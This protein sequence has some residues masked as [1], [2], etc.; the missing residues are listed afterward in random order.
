MAGMIGIPSASEPRSNEFFWSLQRVLR[1]H[2]DVLLA[3]SA[4][5]EVAVNRNNLAKQALAAECEWLW[6]ADDDTI[7]QDD[8]L[9]RMVPHLAE[10]EIVVPY[11]V[12]RSLPF[13]GLLYQWRDGSVVTPNPD[14]GSAVMEIDQG[15][16]GGMLIATSAFKKM[17][18]PWF[19]VGEVD[20]EHQQDDTMF[21]K[22]AR[23]AGVRIVCDPGVLIGHLLR[24][25]AW[26]G[27]ND[28]IVLGMGDGLAV[29]VSR[30]YIAGAPRAGALVG[31]GGNGT[32]GPPKEM[33][34]GR[35]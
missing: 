23:D 12:R 13:D 26:P 30:A 2:P 19:R 34:N 28:S 29:P 33:A 9:E 31:L 11:M 3:V 7:F 17:Q 15:T 21:C 18:Y 25:Y 5:P 27:K 16:T 14:P 24:V 10:A 8:V 6:Q 22:R 20:G 4:G 35:Y 1:R 32:A